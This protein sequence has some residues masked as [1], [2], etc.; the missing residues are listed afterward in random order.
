MQQP[1]QQRRLAVIGAG[2]WGTALANLLA[3]KG[4]RVVLW[5]R[6]SLFAQQLAHERENTLY[7]PGV[8]LH[9]NVAPTAEV[10]EAVQETM[11]F[12]SAVPSHAVRTVWSLFAPLLPAAAV[13]ISTTKGIEAGSF[14]T[15]SQVLHETLEPGMQIHLAVLS[16]P[17]FA[18]EVSC[19]TP[20][21]AVVAASSRRI[22]EEVQQVFSTSAFRLYTSTDVLGVE[23]GGALKN[24]IALAAGVCDGLDFGHNTRAALITRGLAEITQLGIAMGAMAETFAGLSG[25]GDL[26]LTCTGELSRNH[27]VGVRLGQGQKLPE[28]LSQMRMVAEGVTT[29]GSA[30]ALGVRH[31]VEMPIA[32]KVHALLH[33]HV[34]PHEAV[35]ALMTR[36]LKHEGP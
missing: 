20:T 27:T 29:A 16:G 26:V 23:I 7:L 35:V 28:V 32:E 12:I 9:L 10:A 19:N 21:A 31:Q 2:S 34:T 24:V 22:A 13:L 25:I 33:D 6:D 3:A 17:T 36:A 1:G 14:L 4:Y 18:R 30:V 8:P 11:V 5:A 15:M